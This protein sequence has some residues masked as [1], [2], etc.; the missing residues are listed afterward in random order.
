LILI[1]LVTSGCGRNVAG[2]LKEAEKLG[3]TGS[4]ATELCTTPCD[5]LSATYG[6]APDK[7]EELQSGGQ[8]S[9]LR[10]WALRRRW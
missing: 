7:C 9:G 5:D 1:A 8:A 4:Q 6:I 3:V 10:R 2:C